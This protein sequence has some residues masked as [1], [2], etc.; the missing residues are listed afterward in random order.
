MRH[1]SWRV[2]RRLDDPRS[3]PAVWELYSDMRAL[4]LVTSDGFISS[5]RRPATCSQF[6]SFITVSGFLV[7]KRLQ[8]K[9]KK[10]QFMF[11]SSIF[12][13]QSEEK[14]LIPNK[15][16]SH[17]RGGFRRSCCSSCRVPKHRPARSR[18]A[19][20]EKQF[21]K[22]LKFQ[23]A[24]LGESEL[25]WPNSF[26]W[27]KHTQSSDLL[28]PSQDRS[29]AFKALKSRLFEG[30]LSRRLELDTLNLP[31]R[32]SSL[33]KNNKNL[34][35]TCFILLLSVSNFLVSEHLHCLC[36]AAVKLWGEVTSQHHT[37]KSNYD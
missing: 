8:E 32:K 18:G 26:L 35:S 13:L 28:H 3:P 27:Q 22:L 4:R 16:H 14:H 7:S 30:K 37:M 36:D 25:K 2:K 23:I 5:A 31:Q 21:Q 11:L 15:T 34:F 12:F 24:S 19:F 29:G 20:M 33:L 10:G 17:L 9:H 6:S 1:L